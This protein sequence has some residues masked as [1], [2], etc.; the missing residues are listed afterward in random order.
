MSRSRIVAAGVGVAALG[1]ASVLVPAVSS[2][3]QG[4]V[5]APAHTVEWVDGASDVTALRNTQLTTLGDRWYGASFGVGNGDGSVPARPLSDA[6]T[7]GPAGLTL[8]QSAPVVLAHGFAT[9]MQPSAL[10]AAFAGAAVHATGNTNFAIL[11]QFPGQQPIAEFPSS[12]AVSGVDGTDTTWGPDGASTDTTGFAAQLQQEHATIVGYAEYLGLSIEGSRAG[13]SSERLVA[14]TSD[15]APDPTG[16]ATP[17]PTSPA[18]PAQTSTT[19]AAAAR[20]DV[21]QAPRAAAATLRSITFDDVTTLFTPQPSARVVVPSAT[22]SRTAATTTGTLVTGTGFVPGET[23]R[24]AVAQGDRADEIAGTTFTAG[25][26][27]AVAGRVVLPSDFVTDPGRYDLVLVGDS[28]S[29]TATV[30]LT[31][32]GV[33]TT[34]AAV[35]ATPVRTTA[36]FTG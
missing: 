3:D 17:A 22:L 6:A 5:A 4:A 32:T 30:S 10:P 36:T 19:A 28:S 24:V 14:P 29:Q 25:G 12:N 27:G 26:T 31:I 34:P 18:T 7:F 20:A 8:D 9:P 2:A 1:I 33:P 15:A 35:P 21:A 23:V 11:V 13:Q 16:S